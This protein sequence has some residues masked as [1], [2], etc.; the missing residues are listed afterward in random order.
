MIVLADVTLMSF[1]WRLCTLDVLTVRSTTGTVLERRTGYYTV[2]LLCM[3][4]V[5][6][7]T[8]RSTR[9]EKKMRAKKTNQI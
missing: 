2:S 5:P 3:Y 1:R 6:Y 9:V 8:V 4:Y 7:G